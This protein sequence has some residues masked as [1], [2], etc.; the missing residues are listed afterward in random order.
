MKAKRTIL[1]F[2]LLSA[3]IPIPLVRADPGWLAGW[4]YR[5]K[6]T[7]DSGDVDTALTDFPILIYLSNSSGING[8]NINFV[9][10]EVGANSL[11][12]A[13]TLSDGTTECYAE[14]EKWDL[15]NEQA[16]IWAKISAI[17][18]IT[19]TEIYLYYDNDQA[20]NTD[21]VG[22]PNSVPAEN[23]W[24]SGFK[25]VSHMRDDPDNTAIRDSTTNNKDGTKLV[26][27]QPV[28]RVS[29]IIS[30]DQDFDGNDDR[31]GIPNTIMSADSPFSLECW[32]NFDGV[33]SHVENWQILLDMRGQYQ[34]WI[35]I[36]E[37]DEPT[38]PGQ[39]GFNIYDGVD[40]VALF[41]VELNYET[42]YY[43]MATHD[44]AN[45][46]RLYINGVLVDGPDAQDD[47]SSVA[48]QNRIGKD[49]G[50]DTRG[51]F[52]G[53]IDE[54]R[55]SQTGRLG[56]WSKA[57]YET[58]RD[59]ILDFGSEEEP[60]K[61]EASNKLFG[62]GFNASVPN[63]ILRWASNLTDIS[64]FEVQNSTDKISWDYLGQ[65]TTNQYIDLQVTNGLERFYRIRAC[66]YT[67]GAW[68]NSTF[69]DINFEKVYF[70]SGGDGLFP[71]LAI[72]IALLII[73][74]V[75]LESRR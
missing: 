35:V 26:A 57:T 45:N 33:N 4:D 2:L 49:Y 7:I 42:D 62:A 34:T 12:I 67:D 41:S 53:K 17:S 70:V 21:K 73:A 3:L 36:N 27:N 60:P 19:D 69:T 68:D 63:V 24:D 10:D 72:G 22:P 51:N 74:Y 47:P 52:H 56:S 43:V 15:G 9:F 8:E 16:W 32:F 20:D 44:V 25:F 75:Y 29:G 39:V 38:R 54:V 50:A 40:T 6:I 18:N 64:F 37:K 1:F 14:I 61:L 11:K 23:V 28:L 59:H 5:V 65:S 31:I 55:I 71:G 48:Q 30:E 66:N 46:M 58:G 13:V